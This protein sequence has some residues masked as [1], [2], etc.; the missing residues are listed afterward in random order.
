M[1]HDPAHHVRQGVIHIELLRD[2]ADSRADSGEARTDGEGRGGTKGVVVSY[3]HL[4]NFTKVELPTD[5][6][7]LEAVEQRHVPLREMMEREI[8]EQ[9][10]SAQAMRHSQTD[11]RG[12]RLG[13]A[14]Y[15][16]YL[17]ADVED[18]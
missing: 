12:K 1:D 3:A 11:V 5:G 9:R 18:G 2:D 16:G 7:V 14:A 6:K 17:R 10:Q 8:E 15:P 4:Q 13:R